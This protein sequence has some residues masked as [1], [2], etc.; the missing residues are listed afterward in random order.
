M[1]K[2][3]LYWTLMAAEFSVPRFL[4]WLG[5]SSASLEFAYEEATETALYEL[6]FE[7]GVFS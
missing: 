7:P 6:T 3:E 5:G 4:P 1:K 2:R